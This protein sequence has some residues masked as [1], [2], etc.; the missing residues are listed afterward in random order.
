MRPRSTALRC[1]ACAVDV[2]LAAFHA[3]GQPGVLTAP[4]RGC[5]ERLSMRWIAEA[6]QMEVSIPGRAT[7]GGVRQANP[8]LQ[9]LLATLDVERAAMKQ[10][11]SVRPS[12]A[13]GQ[14]A[15]R[16]ALLRSLEAYVTALSKA[17][18]PVPPRLRDELSL[19]RGLDIKPTGGGAYAH[20]SATRRRWSL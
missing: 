7:G 14:L 6:A 12:N 10:A 8:T 16:R 19:Q 20:R 9:A 3:S 1:P 15:A 11:L 18:L 4:C 2:P 17:N 5:G 13:P